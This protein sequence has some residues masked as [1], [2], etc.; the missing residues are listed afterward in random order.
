MEHFSGAFAIRCCDDGSMHPHKISIQEELMYRSSNTGT[1]TEHGTE[2]V[3]TRAQMS[4][5]SQEL[6][7]VTFL[8]QGI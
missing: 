2:Q 4:N 3:G 6:R 5:G 1:G 8:L 7:G